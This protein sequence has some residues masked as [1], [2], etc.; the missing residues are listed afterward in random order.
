MRTIRK[1]DFGIH[2]S[3]SAKGEVMTTTVAEMKVQQLRKELADA[4]AAQQVKKTL[5]SE[6][7]D[8]D[9]AVNEAQRLVTVNA[10]RLA[11]EV[12]GL[13]VLSKEGALIQGMSGLRVNHDAKTRRANQTVRELTVESEKLAL[14]L[15]KKQSALGQIMKQVAE[16]PAYRAVR[17]K[18]CG[19]VADATKLASALF[20]VPLDDLNSVLRKISILSEAE[21][22]LIGDARSA[23]RD[24][25]LPDIKPLLARFV[26]RVT[27]QAVLDALPGLRTENFEAIRQITEIASRDVLR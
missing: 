7:A 4:E 16:H 13:D 26:Q 15:R 20:K 3:R 5:T 1:L 2:K 10:A 23:L 12:A 19:L 18:Q 8:G 6:L 24:A 21:N 9:A 17:E 22:R 27:P 11:E 14:D 25:G